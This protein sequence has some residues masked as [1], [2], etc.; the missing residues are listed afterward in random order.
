[1]E[2]TY[3]PPAITKALTQQLEESTVQNDLRDKA[4]DVYPNPAGN[5][6]VVYNYDI[7]PTHIFLYDV[8]GKL[9]MSRQSKDLATRLD[10]TKL[11]S[12]VYV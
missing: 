4:I 9:V 2:F 11:V 8:S 3:Q 12:G 5:Y 7:S 10:V 6:I 1:L